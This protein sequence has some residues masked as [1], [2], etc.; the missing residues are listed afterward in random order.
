M[1]LTIWRLLNAIS[2]VSAVLFSM[3]MSCSQRVR[4][5]SNPFDR[6]IAHTKYSLPFLSIMHGKRV[7]LMVFLC[8]LRRNACRFV[9]F[10]VSSRL[11][12]LGLSCSFCVA[13]WMSVHLLNSIDISCLCSTNLVNQFSWIRII[14]SNEVTFGYR[15]TGALC[16]RHLWKSH[17]NHRQYLLAIGGLCATF[18]NHKTTTN[19]IQQKNLICLPEMRNPSEWN[20]I[21]CLSSLHENYNQRHVQNIIK[22]NAYSRKPLLLNSYRTLRFS[23]ETHFAMWKCCAEHFEHDAQLLCH[24]QS[25]NAD[26]FCECTEWNEEQNKRDEKKRIRTWN[27]KTNRQNARQKCE[28]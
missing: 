5:P 20:A 27:L 9:H 14:N 17:L 7:W 26:P 24:V 19:S 21:I 6:W 12:Q 25:T 4:L 23:G 15:S 16:L 1:C 28:H 2:H 10:R 8:W 22:S 11:V 18:I 3:Q 13:F